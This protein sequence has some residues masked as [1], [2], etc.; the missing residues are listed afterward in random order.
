MISN[1]NV[2]LVNY[3]GIKPLQQLSSMIVNEDK[4]TEKLTNFC[5]ARAHYPAVERFVFHFQFFTA[6]PIFLLMPF[7]SKRVI[8]SLV[9]AKEELKET[10][11]G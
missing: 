11:T 4:Q 5:R 2:K 9:F 10:D 8:H 3:V 1:K 7:F 6:T